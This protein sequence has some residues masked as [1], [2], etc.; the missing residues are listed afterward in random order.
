MKTPPAVVKSIVIGDEEN[1]GDTAD[2]VILDERY[3]P[4][5][6]SAGSAYVRVASTSWKWI[7]GRS[8]NNVGEGL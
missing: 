5:L 8:R 4:A 2:I 1:T 7:V 3:R 6:V